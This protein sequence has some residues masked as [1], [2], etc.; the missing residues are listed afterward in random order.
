MGPGR[1]DETWDQAEEKWLPKNICV[2]HLWQIIYPLLK[3]SLTLD[4]S[5]D[6]YNNINLET[7]F[8]HQAFEEK[9]SAENRTSQKLYMQHESEQLLLCCSYVISKR[10]QAAWWKDCSI[11]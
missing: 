2:I 4:A 5:I 11:A 3:N 1:E 6:R 10:A 7:S 9:A 8:S